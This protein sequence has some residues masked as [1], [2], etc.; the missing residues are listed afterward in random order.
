MVQTQGLVFAMWS[1][2]PLPASANSSDFL[3]ED[4]SELGFFVFFALTAPTSA[5]DQLS[6]TTSVLS[7]L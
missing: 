1:I 5:S 2:S 6:Y 4:Q 7:P 3:I